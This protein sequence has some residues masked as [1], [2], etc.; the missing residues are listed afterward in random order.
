MRVF[1]IVFLS[2]FSFTVQSQIYVGD[3]V[4]EIIADQW[5]DNPNSIF[6][7]YKNKVIVLDFWFTSC[8]PCLYT[9]PHL[10]DLAEK[11]RNSNISFVAI[12]FEGQKTVEEFLRKKKLLAM[13]GSDTTYRLI[14]DYRVGSYPHTF[15][16][17][18]DGILRWEGY[19][20]WLTEE[21]IDAVLK[22]GYYPKLEEET[23][24][25]PSSGDVIKKE[26][27]I[28]IMVNDYSSGS[29]G[30]MMNKKELSFQNQPLDEILA[31]LLETSKRVILVNDSIRN[32]DIRFKVPGGMRQ[33]KIKPKVAELIIN[34]LEFTAT[35]KIEE[36]D[37]YSLT[38]TNDSLFL[39]NAIDTTMI[40]HGKST[41]TTK[42]QW[43]G[44]GIGMLDLAREL[45]NRYD[46]F[47]FDNTK[48]NGFFEFRLSTESLDRAISDLLK[49]YGLA[50]IAK[51]QQVELLVL[52]RNNH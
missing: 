31:L 15:L 4:P 38:L 12:T 33:D 21:M 36:V 27:S 24:V 51:N 45:E 49:I 46:V 34:E 3:T 44:T 8:V 42:T 37:G 26:Y 5:V 9:M 43:Q 40:Y 6:S 18:A 13:V 17:D 23:S 39:A 32:Y 22:K 47:I 35:K 48:M 52:E 14:N 28:D 2:V 7:D 10:N 19:P 1:L 11:Y 16:I 25:S 29:S 20:T 41:S 30:M 50:L